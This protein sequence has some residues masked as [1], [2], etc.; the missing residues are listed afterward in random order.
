[1]L[2][3][4]G[5]PVESPQGTSVMRTACLLENSFAAFTLAFGP[6]IDRRL[7]LVFDRCAAAA[8]WRR[9]C[10]LPRQGVAEASFVA[11]AMRLNVICCLQIAVSGS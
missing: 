3:A 4:Q 10:C 11:G 9:L 8:F 2:T 6:P 1:V 5:S 7:L